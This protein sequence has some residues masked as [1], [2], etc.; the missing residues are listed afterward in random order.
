VFRIRLQDLGWSPSV[1][2]VATGDESFFRFAPEAAE[3]RAL[4]SDPAPIARIDEFIAQ[5]SVAPRY[6]AIQ[7]LKLRLDDFLKQDLQRNLLQAIYGEVIAGT[8]QMKR[9]AFNNSQV[10]DFSR[11]IERHRS[12]AGRTF[13]MSSEF[14]TQNPEQDPFQRPFGPAA[15]A[16]AMSSQTGN[17]GNKT[18]E[19]DDKDQDSSSAFLGGFPFTNVL[20]QLGAGGAANTVASAQSGRGGTIRSYRADGHDAW[21]LCCSR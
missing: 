17:S 12:N 15:L 10:A 3:L 14:G 20:E 4:M 2:Q 9:L 1:W 8:A 6:Y 21:L 13:W 7:G 16:L 11:V 19:S 18:A 5:N